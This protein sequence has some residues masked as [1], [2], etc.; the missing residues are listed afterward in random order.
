MSKIS[1]SE[2]TLI[3]HFLNPSFLDWKTADS[4]SPDGDEQDGGFLETFEREMKSIA[5]MVDRQE[6]GSLDLAA[7][8]CYEPLVEAIQTCADPQV[9]EGWGDARSRNLVDLVSALLLIL[10]RQEWPEATYVPTMGDISEEIAENWGEEFELQDRAI[11]LEQLLEMR[12]CFFL[13]AMDL[14]ATLAELAAKAEYFWHSAYTDS[15]PGTI[16]RYALHYLETLF[17]KYKHKEPVL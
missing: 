12:E 15:I 14:E 5:S 3:F 11:H 1:P 17:D 6:V 16:G 10:P 13:N 7:D 2:T 4:S 9:P 8:S